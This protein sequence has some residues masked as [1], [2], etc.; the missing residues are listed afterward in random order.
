MT[1]EAKP[2]G[3]SS[4]YNW[5]IYADNGVGKT[6]FIGTGG[7]EYKILL[8][9]PPV[10]HVDPI[11]GSGVQEIVVHDWE[12][13]TEAQDMLAHVKKGE[14]DW[15]WLDDISSW[16]D[17]G[18]EDVYQGILDRAGPPG[19]PGRKAREQF[20]A[21]KGEFRTNA[22]RI[23]ALVR[24]LVGS[25]AF[26]FGITAHPFWGPRLV[27]DDEAEPAINS[28]QIQPWIQ[29]KGMVN[30]VC[31][32]MNLVGYMEVAERKRGGQYRRLLTN[33]GP[34][35]YAKCQYIDANRVNVFGES[36]IIVNPTLPEMMK[37]IGS[38]RR[39]SRRTRQRPAVR[40]RTRA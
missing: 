13:M 3:E 17:V 26:N 1:V 18:L 32:Y 37:V 2:A 8:I 10:V 29:V 20:R 23:S 33:K 16:Q 30:K 21:D 25:D 14:W 36:G 40:R 24:D 15:V 34:R 22:E 9:R 5:L 19:S 6:S 31:G 7:K 35:H 39:P 12:D 28:E 11:V 38:S 27:T 4:T